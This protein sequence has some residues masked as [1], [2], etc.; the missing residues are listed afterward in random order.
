MLTVASGEYLEKEGQEDRL[1][2]RQVAQG[3]GKQQHTTRLNI[4]T[5]YSLL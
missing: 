3:T 5:A 1:K 4:K 2:E